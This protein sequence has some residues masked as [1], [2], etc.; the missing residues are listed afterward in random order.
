MESNATPENTPAVTESQ[1]S[2]EVAA[3]ADAA[4]KASVELFELCAAILLGLGATLG[5]IA[6]Y[7]GGLWGGKSIESFGMSSRVTTKSADAGTFADAKISSDSLVKLQVIQLVS[8]AEHT[9]KG[10]ERDF[11]LHQISELMIREYSDEAYDAIGLPL[12][13][14]KKYDADG[15]LADLPEDVV[16]EASKQDFS[17]DYF[18]WMYEEKVK[19]TV[20]AEELFAQGQHEGTVGDQFAL[21]GV[22]YTMSL[23]F[24]GLGLVF[25]SRVRWGFFSLGTLIFLGALVYMCRLEWA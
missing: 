4:S 20:K 16:F 3:A 6:G 21:D 10:E 22:Y 9:P 23:F 13:P 14:R 15:T 2:A 25:K 7:Q 12:E 18:Q 17:K 8:R 5:S 24:A 11:L 1:T 19:H